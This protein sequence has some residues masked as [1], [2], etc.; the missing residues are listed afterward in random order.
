MG[1]KA[2]TLE[3]EKLRLD[4]IGD[5]E[6][7]ALEGYCNECKQFVVVKMKVLEYYRR[8]AYADKVVD[9][10]AMACSKCNSRPHRPLR[11]RD[12]RE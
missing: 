10:L 12:V 7:V 5:V 9:G 4:L 2:Q 11:L 8:L 6:L 3:Y 1:S